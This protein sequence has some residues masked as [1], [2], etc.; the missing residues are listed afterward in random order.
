MGLIQGV[1]LP[2]IPVVDDLTGAT[3]ERSCERNP[4]EE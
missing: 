3:D 1:D 4:C 2:V